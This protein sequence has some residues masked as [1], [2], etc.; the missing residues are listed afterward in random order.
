M[1]VFSDHEL[2]AKTL[3]LH[4]A[5]K[6]ENSLAVAVYSGEEDV[7]G[8]EDAKELTQFFWSMSD[9]AAEDHSKESEI[10]QQYDLEFWMERLMNITIGYLTSLGYGDVWRDESYRINS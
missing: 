7:Q 3:A 8:I 10:S 5:N 2:T 9:D 4:Y 6:S 1:M